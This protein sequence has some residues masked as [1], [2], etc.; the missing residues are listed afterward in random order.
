MSANELCLGCGKIMELLEPGF[1][2]H[3][4]CIPQFVPI[5]GS[6][7]M[8]LYDLE[9]RED[10]LEV[11]RWASRNAKRS[12]QVAL[13]CSE[14]GH[15]CDRRIAYTMS[16]L[17]G[18]GGGSDP[19][20]SIVGTSIHAWMEQAFE[21][22]QQAHGISDWLTELEIHPSPL[23]K[24]HSDLY[25]A[26]RQLVLDWKFPGPDA[27]R[28]MRS[29]GPSQ[30]YLVQVQLYGLGQILSGRPV[31]RVGVVAVN[32]AGWLKD[33]LIHTVE[34][35]RRVADAALKR[36]YDLGNK[37]IEMDILNSPHRW[38]EIPASPSRLCGWCPF[39]RSKMDS[40]SDR[41][42]PGK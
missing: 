10:L 26:P 41:G 23:V 24:G 13:G 35:D 15:E 42:C 11:V 8:T 6:H 30:Q 7:G 4:N 28:K 25:H 33:I 12:Q 32:R 2:Y 5:P 40:A 38:E 19:W 29:D 31:Q 18:S 16:G 20:P 39:Y 27:F 14:V 22:Y 21:A 34:F 9:L 17:P 3:P 1:L 36:V 37:M